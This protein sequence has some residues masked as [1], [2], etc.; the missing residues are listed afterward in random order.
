LILKQEQ[1][2]KEKKGFGGNSRRKKRDHKEFQEKMLI[3]ID[4]SFGGKEKLRIREKIYSFLL[5][6]YYPKPGFKI[7]TEF[8]S[9]NLKY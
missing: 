6:P 5:V 7:K 1:I 4:Q 2:P 8:F 9:I 3:F